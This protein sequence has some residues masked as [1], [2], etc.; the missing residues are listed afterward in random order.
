[1]VFVD[2]SGLLMAPLVRRSWAPRG[3]TPVLYQRTR[4]HKKVS[5]IAALCVS[6][7]KDRV[8]LYFRLHPDANINAAYVVDFLK[9]LSRQLNGPIVL[10]WDCLQAH[11]K[12]NDFVR[13]SYS[14]YSFFL[15]PY[16]PE[17]NPVENIWSY[18]KINPMANRASLDID[19]LAQ[20][21]RHHGRS[22]QRKKNL[23]RSFLKHTPLSLRLK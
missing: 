12:A 22:M 21:A 11:R 5:I 10:I 4:S 19:S 6:P 18:L 9:N 8:Q 1:M 23:L 2:E 14:L 3:H 13:R 17:L 7:T 20:T 15:P 16:A